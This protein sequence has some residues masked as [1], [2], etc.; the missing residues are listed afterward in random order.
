MS[1]RERLVGAAGLSEHQ[2]EAHMAKTPSVGICVTGE[3]RSFERSNVRGSLRLLVDHLPKPLLRI[4]VSRKTRP[5]PS[6]RWRV[7]QQAAE[8]TLEYAQLA[9]EFPEAFIELLDDSNCS[10]AHVRKSACCRNGEAPQTF[11]Q[12]QAITRCVRELMATA[13]AGALTHVVRLRADAI[14]DDPITLASIILNVSA[15]RPTLAA[16]D[17]MRR[18]THPTDTLMVSPAS[19]A[20][21]FFR[22]F[23]D[24]IEEECQTKNKARLANQPQPEMTWHLCAI[25]VYDCGFRTKFDVAPFAHYLVDLTGRPRCSRWI[26][27]NVTRC[28]ER[29]YAALQAGKERWHED[30][31]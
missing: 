16:K 10:L 19:V 28:F 31:A 24:P 23:V 2:Y 3:A 6:N 8:M 18:R 15:T 20:S 17:E 1:L 11:M 4:S 27:M 30:A 12:Y 22:T 5:R 26:H 13:T 21:D 25:G 9:N 7:G 14:Y 29:G